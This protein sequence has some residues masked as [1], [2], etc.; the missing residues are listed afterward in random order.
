MVLG[1]V[2]RSAAKG[3]MSMHHPDEVIQY[4][5]QAHRLVFGYGVIPWEYR[6]GM[7]Q[8]LLPLLLA[9]PMK[10]GDLIAPAS[11]LYLMLPRMAVAM[12]SISIMAAALKLGNGISRLHGLVAMFRSAERRVGKECVSTCRSRW[13]PDH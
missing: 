5:E 2:L 8:R 6:Y 12:L 4:L 9:G 13:S 11:D 3:P 7:R 1:I 10:L